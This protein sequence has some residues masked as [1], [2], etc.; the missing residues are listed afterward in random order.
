[1]LT[2]QITLASRYLWG[3]KLRT[4]LTTL[5][6]L[7]GT[8]VIFGMGILL[9]TM[10]QA[11]QANMLAASGQVDIT[12]THESGEAFS[13]KTIQKIRGIEN[14]RAI[15]GS[16]SRTINIPEKYFGDANIT[17]LTLTGIDARAAQ[18]LHNY[19][20]KEG[21]FLRSADT[22]AAVISSSLAENLGLKI[23][24]ELDLPTT[25]GAISLQIVGLLPARAL[26]GNEEVLITLFEAQKLLDLPNRI[27]S[28][29]INLNTTDPA[30]RDIIQKSIEGILGGDYSLGALSSGTEI[31]ASLQIGQ[32]AFSLFGF[33]AIFM[34]GFIIFN[35]FRTILAER[36]RD[37]GMLRTIGASRAT[38]V[39]LI[40]VEGLLQGAVG[41]MAGMSL[42]YLMGS[43]LL[44]L[45]SPIMN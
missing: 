15:S 10:I 32:K 5:A 18:S 41:T 44:R 23:G 20:V 19:P 43:G 27:N 17:A 6:I 42:G 12:I 30:Q 37:I 36:R 26:P 16:L 1:M 8:L 25:E 29:E 7:L 13:E 24:D 34:G 31:F 3:R 39:G 14:I 35:T 38:I 28:I 9:P 4:F 11:F 40:L 45:M 33:L 2:F 21:R 22:T